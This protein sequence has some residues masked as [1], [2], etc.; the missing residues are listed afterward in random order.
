MYLLYSCVEFC[1]LPCMYI[2]YSC[3]IL[4]SASGQPIRARSDPCTG[5]PA[6]TQRHGVPRFRSQV[7]GRVE[8]G[9]VQ[10]S[11]HPIRGENYGLATTHNIIRLLMTVTLI[12]GINHIL[13]RSMRRYIPGLGCPCCIYISYIIVAHIGGTPPPC[14]S[15]IQSYNGESKPW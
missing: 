13:S 1:N 5:G 9:P 3:I 15:Y 6:E 4:Y 2:V 11:W 7:S 10:A 12:I 8:Q 14:G